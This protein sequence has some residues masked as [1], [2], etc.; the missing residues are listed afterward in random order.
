MDK[1]LKN[2]VLDRFF[3][4]RTI[5]KALIINSALLSIACGGKSADSDTDSAFRVALLTPGPISDQAWNGAA[6]T[7]LERIRDSLGASISHIQTKTPA[8]FD[9]NF[10]QY[11]SQGY[12]LVIGHGFEFQEA[13]RRVAPLYRKTRYATTG[14]EGLDSTVIALAFAFNEPAYLAGMAAAAVSKTGVIGVIGGTEL[15]PVK[16]GFAEF[17]GD[18]DD[19]APVVGESACPTQQVVRLL[20]GQHG[21]WLVED[22]GARV[23]RQR[24]H[25]LHALLRADREV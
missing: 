11:G 17:V 7:G 2:N 4:A 21:G 6:Y 23:A 13:A 18:E 5:R 25:D 15:P 19:T 14:G 8:E 16:A 20:G 9:E 12:D 24:P 22:Q 3:Q 10:R 1:S